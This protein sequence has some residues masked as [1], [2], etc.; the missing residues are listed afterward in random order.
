MGAKQMNS[1]T[2]ARREQQNQVEG[3][4]SWGRVSKSAAR[5]ELLHCV[6]DLRPYLSKRPQF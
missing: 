4:G 2:C 1:K 6:Y 5:G 3:A